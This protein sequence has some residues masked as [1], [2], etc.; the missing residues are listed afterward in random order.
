MPN[1]QFHFCL[2][3]L[4]LGMSVFGKAGYFAP[5]ASYESVLVPCF[6][7]QIS[8]AAIGLSNEPKQS[9]IGPML[10]EIRTFTKL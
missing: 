1:E 6:I 3:I 7:H 10:A 5:Y 9:L 2:K 8:R 4:I